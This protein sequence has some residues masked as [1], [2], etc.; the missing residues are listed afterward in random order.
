MLTESL[1]I[2]NNKAFP[3]FCPLADTKNT[4]GQ[5]RIWLQQKSCKSKQRQKTKHRS[6][7]FSKTSNLS[8]KFLSPPFLPLFNLFRTERPLSLIVG[9]IL[10]Q[11]LSV[12]FRAG[13]GFGTL[14]GCQMKKYRIGDHCWRK[15]NNKCWIIKLIFSH[16]KR[17]KEDR[18]ESEIN[19]QDAKREREK[20]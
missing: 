2:W 9:I 19:F 6:G 20:S 5:Q 1:L 14:K 4:K 15:A 13:G 12:S 3:L 10:S 11:V 18:D 7:N 8:R 17:R 16:L